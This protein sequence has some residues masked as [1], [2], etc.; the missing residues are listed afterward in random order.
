MEPYVHEVLH[1]NAQEMRALAAPHTRHL[2]ETIAARNAARRGR[3]LAWLRAAVAMLVRHSP[4]ARGP[5]A[6]G[7][8]PG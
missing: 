5:A 7:G 2:H 6:A 1:R 3:R 8:R 4:A